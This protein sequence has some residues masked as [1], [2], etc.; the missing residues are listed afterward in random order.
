[1]MTLITAAKETRV[2]NE[3]CVWHEGFYIK[4]EEESC[5]RHTRDEFSNSDQNSYAALLFP[6]RNPMFREFPVRSS[7]FIFGPM[8]RSY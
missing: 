2:Y 4:L 5:T 8:Q 1:M 3:W 6:A 7:P